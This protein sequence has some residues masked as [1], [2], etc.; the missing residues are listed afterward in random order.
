MY[1][2]LNAELARLGWSR[3][4]L[5]DKL[6]IRYATILDKLNGKYPLTYDECVRIK[7]L[8]GLTFLLKFFFLPSNTKYRIGL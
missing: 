4:V 5:A 8:W 2:N 7:N 6:K 1:P 3:K